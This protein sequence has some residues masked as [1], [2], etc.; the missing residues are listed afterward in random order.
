MNHI[1]YR[2][3]VSQ[4]RRS[5]R[6]FSQR[7]KTEQNRVEQLWL[8]YSIP[9]ISVSLH[10][11]D[12]FPFDIVVVVVVVVVVKTKKHF[13]GSDDTR[14][15]A[16]DVHALYWPHVWGH[17]GIVG[18]L[19]S[20]PLGDWMAQSRP[21]PS[22]A[23]LMLKHYQSIVKQKR[24]HDQESGK[25]VSYD[26]FNPVN[27]VSGL[28]LWLWAPH[29]RL[30]R[31]GHICEQQTLD[32]SGWLLSSQVWLGWIFFEVE[33]AEMQSMLSSCYFQWR[34]FLTFLN[35]GEWTLHTIDWNILWYIDMIY[36]QESISNSCEIRCE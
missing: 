34:G 16:H 4:A 10:C 29:H 9:I 26:V 2:T 25:Y 14:R 28:Y 33:W 27:W 30:E 13:W 6:A 32:Y 15:I 1:S 3:G 20:S 31:S 35:S 24:K 18:C 21:Y 22:Q 23:Y 8:V 11:S 17:D 19:V 5:G 36:S 12:T 7:I